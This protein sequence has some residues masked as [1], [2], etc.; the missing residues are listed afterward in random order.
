MIDLPSDIQISLCGLVTLYFDLSL[1]F[2]P[3][4]AQCLSSCSMVYPY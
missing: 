4:L 1:D 3:C 2:S